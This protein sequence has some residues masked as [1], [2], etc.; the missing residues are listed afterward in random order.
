MKD[1]GSK[2]NETK[3]F[4]KLIVELARILWCLTFTWITFITNLHQMQLRRG[5][6]TKA[7]GIGKKME[8][9]QP[10]GSQPS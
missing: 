3:E 1:I 8:I 4:E 9:V 6:T 2:G 5:A 7:M 10:S